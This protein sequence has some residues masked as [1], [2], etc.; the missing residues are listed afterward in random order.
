MNTSRVPRRAVV[1]CALVTLLLVLRVWL[2]PAGHPWT[3]WVVVVGLWWLLTAAAM[4]SRGW[5]AA[6]TCTMAYLLGIHLFRSLPTAL[7]WWEHHH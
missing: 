2:G 4:N 5:P 7:A 1:E 6:T 3:D